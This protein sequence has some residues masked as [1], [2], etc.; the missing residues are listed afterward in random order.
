MS[1]TGV[2]IAPENQARIF[3]EFTQEDASTTRRFGG[4]GLGLSISRQIVELMGGQLTLASATGMGS[5][6]SF[7]LVAPLC[8][9]VTPAIAPPESLKGLRTLVVDDN[10]AARGITVRALREWGAD[11]AGVAT[12]A[13]ALAELRA[14][15]YDVVIIDDPMTD[16]SAAGLLDQLPAERVG[17]LRFIRL[18]S[19]VDVSTAATDRAFEAELT[20]PLH[21]LQLHQALL[22]RKMPAPGRQALRAVETSGP[23]GTIR[24]RLSGRVLV[25][26]DQ[27]LNREVAHGMLT[28]L[29]LRVE[30]A[31][32]GYEALARLERERFD[33]VLMDCEMP[34]MD[35]L[36]AASA[37]REREG[38]GPRTPIVALTADA[39]GTG[40]AAC[41]AAGMDD[42]LTKPF[43]RDA[44]HTTLAKWLVEGAV[45]AA[46][47]SV[48]AP[49]AA[50]LLLDR[51]TLDALRALPRSG[52]K[53][54]LSHIGEIYL[55]D[56]SRL[57]E[58]I[59]QA[60]RA[61]EVTSLAR[62]AHAWRSYNGNVGAH[63]LAHLCRELENHA[64]GGNLAA[65]AGTFAQLQVLHG[66]VRDE[67]QFEMRRSA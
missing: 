36:S 64:R 21:L 17:R 59:E 53:D 28:S 37:L 52:P 50:E 47:P 24:P 10:T 63:A 40:R 11:P 13:G 56:S 1:D 48:A 26:E 60:L 33:L 19:F 58:A 43:S 32:D 16:G 20:K 15:S 3:E 45:T 2:G 41:L 22:G 49:P 31:N 66:R 12:L 35:G 23:H 9:P 25:V 27:P 67:L 55:S 54:M 65:A 62:A 38:G 34:V 51:A 46:A 4:T 29:G 5:T 57:V 18:V 30:T 61:G 39:T 44:L 8:D 42:Y 6:F 14:A 7:E